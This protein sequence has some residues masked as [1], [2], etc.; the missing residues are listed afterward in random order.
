[1]FEV[2]ITIIIIIIIDIVV[3]LQQYDFQVSSL[4]SLPPSSLEAYS[5]SLDT[6]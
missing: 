4:K 1:M 5:E 3:A 6:V 2:P